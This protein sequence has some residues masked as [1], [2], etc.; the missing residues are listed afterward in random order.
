MAKRRLAR[1]HHRIQLFRLP[2]YSPNFNPTEGA[3]KQTKKFTTHNRFFHTTDERDPALV[4]T[5]ERFKSNPS[6]LAGHVARFL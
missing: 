5:F 2:P 1:N 6:L 4:L 3:W